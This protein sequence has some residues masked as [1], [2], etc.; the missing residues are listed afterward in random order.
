[1]DYALAWG[2]V[3]FALGVSFVA[4]KITARVEKLEEWRAEARVQHTDNLAALA[5]LR[6]EVRILNSDR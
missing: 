6:Q 2:V 4:G 5:E 1:M 3:A